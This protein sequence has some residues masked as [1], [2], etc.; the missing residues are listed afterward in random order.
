MLALF[1][2]PAAAAAA[3]VAAVAGG[4]A[5]GKAAKRPGQTVM[6]PLYSWPIEI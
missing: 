1:T 5:S 2:P 3:A 4:A 6:F